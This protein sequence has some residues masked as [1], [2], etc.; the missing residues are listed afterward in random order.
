MTDREGCRFDR[1][2]F[3][4]LSA[5]REQHGEGADPAV[6]IPSERFQ[7]VIRLFPGEL[8]LQWAMSQRSHLASVTVSKPIKIPTCS[9]SY[10]R[11]HSKPMSFSILQQQSKWASWFSFLVIWR[12][13][14]PE[15]ERCSRVL[16]YLLWPAAIP[17]LI[18]PRCIIHVSLHPSQM[19]RAQTIA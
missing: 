15:I 1:G 14:R 4:G 9:G 16:A 6:Q 7:Q 3:L 12:W 8:P 18:S 2:S 5:L 13:W 10:P 19:A 17:T 11:N